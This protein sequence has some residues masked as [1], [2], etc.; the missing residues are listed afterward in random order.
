M[1]QW[2][3]LK[4]IFYGWRMIA[5]GSAFRVVG[6]GLHMYGFT[7][8]F[9]PLTEELKLTRAA[10]SLIFS[11][12]RAEGAIEAPAVGYLIDRFGPRPVMFIT[13]LL[14]GVGYL[15]LSTAQTYVGLLVVY[16]GVIS[17]SF[18]AG[19]MHAPMALANNWF[20]RKRTMAMTFISSSVGVG[21]TLLAPLLSF[22]V[23]EWGWRA[24]ALA[25]GVVFLLVTAPLTLF[26]QPSPESVGLLP[27]GVAGENR[28]P[29]PDG[30]ART[31]GAGALVEQEATLK[32][33]IRTAAFWTL[34]LASAFRVFGL[35]TF[36]VHFIPIMIWKGASNQEA[37]FFLGL[38]AL[39]SVP[40]TF[41]VAWLADRFNK[42]LTMGAGMLAATAG[43]AALVLSKG[44]ET[45]WLFAVLLTLAEALFPVTWATVGDF[46][47][48]KSFATIRGTITAFYM[49]GS[50]LAPVAAGWIYDRTGSYVFM[51]WLILALFLFSSLLY[52]ATRRPD[53]RWRV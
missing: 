46:F 43:I 1:L 19:F 25:A 35:V 20:V 29:R 4:N 38:F 30:T 24:G 44:S 11:L 36:S 2:T 34:M 10:T 50:M 31:I 40:T 41:V 14:V 32:Q 49:G 23:Y 42:P 26:V 5:I 53:L 3:G 27:D 52:A 45:L 16:L 6:G 15:L 12:S 17:L 48:R 13:A 9:L 28:S 22:V 33:A 21:G 51:L 18:S 47:G 7:I 37:A 8:F 39:V